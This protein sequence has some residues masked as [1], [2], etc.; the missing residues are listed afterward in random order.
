MVESLVRPGMVHQLDRPTSYYR[1]QKGGGKDKRK[2]V[3]LKELNQK[4]VK[5]WCL[6]N[7]KKKIYRG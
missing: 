1:D 6:H 5:S 4:R 7:I 2:G 3:L